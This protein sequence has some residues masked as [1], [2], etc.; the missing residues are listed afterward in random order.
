[1]NYLKKKF[2]LKIPFS[3]LKIIK[4]EKTEQTR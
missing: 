2:F 4:Y 1:M 3:E